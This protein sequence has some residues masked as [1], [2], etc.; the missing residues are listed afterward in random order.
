MSAG[1]FNSIVAIVT[2]VGLARFLYRPK[3]QGS[4]TYKATVV[5]LAS[6]MDVGFIVFTPILVLLVGYDAPWAMLGLCLLAILTGFAFSY[7]INNYEPLVGTSDPLHRWDSVAVWALVVASVANIA[8]YALLL[9]TLVLLPLGDVYSAA[10]AA[11]T[12]AVRRPA[13][14]DRPRRSH[15]AHR[16]APGPAHSRDA[17]QRRRGAQ[18]HVPARRRL[19][20]HPLGDAGRR[21]HRRHHGRAGRVRAPRDRLLRPRARVAPVN[22]ARAGARGQGP[23]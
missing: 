20:H 23:N 16:P 19:D 10:L 7:N 18:P 3:V 4:T 8:Y 17:G 21:P 13:A 9:M 14:A 6:I 2:L 1:L 22:D 15:A 12:A 5:P 11:G